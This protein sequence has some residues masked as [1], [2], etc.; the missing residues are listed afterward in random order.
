M[1][2]S[3]Y[4]Y[5]V[6]NDKK[7]KSS[8]IVGNQWRRMLERE[9]KWVEESEQRMRQCIFLWWKSM[10]LQH[11]WVFVRNGNW[12][13]RRRKRD[14]LLYFTY[15]VKRLKEK[16]KIEFEKVPWLVSELKSIKFL[17]PNGNPVFFIF[18]FWTTTGNAMRAIHISDSSTHTWP[19]QKF[20]FFCY[21]IEPILFHF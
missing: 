12:E 15:G 10:H 2:C 17:Q 8:Y 14:G 21:S 7:E 19:L 1:Q 4:D 5:Q 3:P 13:L 18:F 9:S 11:N 20:F 16:Q 6:E